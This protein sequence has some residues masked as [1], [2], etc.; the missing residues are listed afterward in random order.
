MTPIGVLIVDDS[1]VVRG[2]LTKAFQAQDDL[3]VIA[4]ASNGALGIEAAERHNPDV[5]ILDIEMPVMDGRQAVAELRERY[6]SLPI[7]M[8]STLTEA[9]AAATIA[10]MKAGASD[11]ALKPSTNSG[12]VS[13]VDGVIQDLIEKIRALAGAPTRRATSVQPAGLRSTSTPQT[14]RPS[15]GP[16]VATPNRPATLQRVPER[17]S[18]PTRPTRRP[19]AVAP[20]LIAIGSSTGGPTAL[21]SMFAA[22]ARPLPVPIVLVQHMPP[23]F[24]KALAERLDRKSPM[25]VVEATDGQELRPGHCYVAPGSLHME[26]VK[27]S[28]GAKTRV[29]DGSPVNSCKP[30]VDPLFESAARLYGAGTIGVVLT[31]MGSDGAVGSGALAAAG[32]H[33][34][35]QTEASCVVYG[36]PRAVDEAG[37]SSEQLSVAE[38]VDRL[39]SLTALTNVRRAA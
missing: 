2:I 18:A 19:H 5:V 15:S 16:G 20:Q 31:G 36:M 34:I 27:S 12:V 32:S 21:E 10:C 6:P 38:I 29:Y 8:F 11:F 1:A 3:D 25:T 14:P 17:S 13:S 26:V 22:F 28:V 9:G 23:M 33:V 30:A 7:I 35:T 4:T 37:H 39:E 24:T